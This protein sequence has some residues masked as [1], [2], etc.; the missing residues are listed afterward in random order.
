V[1]YSECGLVPLENPTTNLLV[2][3]TLSHILGSIDEIIAHNGTTSHVHGRAVTPSGKEE[4]QDN[5]ADVFSGRGPG[6]SQK[7]GNVECRTMASCLRRNFTLWTETE[8]DKVLDLLLPPVYTDGHS[9]MAEDKCT[10]PTRW[11]V[12]PFQHIRMA[13]R[14]DLTTQRGNIY[15]EDCI[16]PESRMYR[17][18]TDMD[19]LIG[20]RTSSL[21]S[22]HPGTIA[23][24]E[25]KPLQEF[26][27]ATKKEWANLKLA[28][29]ESVLAN[30][31][32]FLDRNW[33]NEKCLQS[34]YKRVL[35]RLAAKI[36]ECPEKCLVKGA[37]VKLQ[38]DEDGKQK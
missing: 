29:F 10:N 28:L 8:L 2:P 37:R 20:T 31:G 4:I 36:R 7:P 30:G 22:K 3:A 17:E 1:P 25:A 9:F 33:N 32:R 15:C 26:I 38:K 35:D 27:D 24:R 16:E 11:Y 23:F 14:M 5:I 18:Y 13:I 34:Y 21:V 6:A 19:V 12:I